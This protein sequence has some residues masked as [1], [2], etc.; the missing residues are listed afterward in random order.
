[1]TSLLDVDEVVGID[2]C[3]KDSLQRVD[4]CALE[5]SEQFGALLQCLL[6]FV[7]QTERSSLQA[8]KFDNPQYQILVE[9]WDKQAKLI[10]SYWNFKGTP[11]S[12]RGKIAAE[13]HKLAMIPSRFAVECFPQILDEGTLVEDRSSLSQVTVQTFEGTT[14]AVDIPTQTV[15]DYFSFL[16]SKLRDTESLIFRVDE[17]PY[18]EI[19]KPTKEIERHW[20]VSARQ[21]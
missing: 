10:L 21:S 6:E 5:D 9:N 18:F 20:L 8:T 19:Q 15:T 11:L 7:L 16:L 13:L 2:F 14:Q 17:H 12:L 4:I 3:H 1:M